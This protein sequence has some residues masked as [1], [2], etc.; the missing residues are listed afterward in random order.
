MDKTGSKVKSQFE[1]WLE[2]Q[3]SQDCRAVKS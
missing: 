3:L 2:V 1:T